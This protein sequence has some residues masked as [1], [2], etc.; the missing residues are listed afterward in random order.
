LALRRLIQGAFGFLH[1][2]RHG[3]ALAR[4][5]TF[6]GSRRFDTH[7]CVMREK[8]DRFAETIRHIRDGLAPYEVEADQI[9]PSSAVT[10]SRLAQRPFLGGNRLDLLID[11]PATFDAILGE[12]ARTLGKQVRWEV[13]GEQ[14]GVDRDILDKLEAPLSHLIRN[15]LD[16]GLETPA[17]REAADKP[18]V[19]T[20]R[21]EARHRAGM[22]HITITDDG[23][24]IDIGTIRARAVALGLVASEVAAQLSASELL[25]FLFLPGFSTKHVVTEIS[26]RGL[27]LAIV[28]EKAEKLGG[29]VSV[30]TQAGQGT[31]FRILLP[32][33]LATFRGT[34][35]QAAAQT[36]V[37]PTANVE[38][39]GRVR[40]AEIKQ[41]DGGAEPSVHRGSFSV[42]GFAAAASRAAASRWP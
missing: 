32:L 30:Q 33:T 27:G 37:I 9:K 23:E 7:A 20:I 38:R 25:E 6:F 5:A 22:L 1:A 18:P 26:G 11:G 4:E 10:L 41:R 14:T 13:R 16:H 35:V 42:W 34:L 21:L 29:R 19:G 8:F 28:R 17:D 24:G 15:A 39:A 40:V 36:F 12:I 31:T 2:R 3:N